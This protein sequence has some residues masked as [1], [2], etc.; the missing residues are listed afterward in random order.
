MSKKIKALILTANKFEDFELFFPYFRLLEEGIEVDVAGPSKGHIEGEHGYELELEK[1]FDDIKPEDYDLLVIPGGSPDGAPSVVRRD[2]RAQ[3][4]AKS[5]FK[6]NK[7]VSSI[8][9]GPWLLASAGLVNGRRLTSFWH[10]E[11]PEDIKK[12][13][14]IYVDEEVVV[15]GN[16]VTSRYPGDLP[17]FMRETIQMVKRDRK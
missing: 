4:I 13:G 16:L 9:H 14:G 11:V 17:A 10:D 15:D 8:C 5:F 1:T 3:A 6:S 12:A 2:L 7:P